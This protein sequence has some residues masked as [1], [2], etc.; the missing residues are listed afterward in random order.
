MDST[1]NVNPYRQHN[2]GDTLY[3]DRKTRDGRG[4]VRV[5]EWPKIPETR[6]RNQESFSKSL[7]ESVPTDNLDHELAASRKRGT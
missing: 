7:W 4:V 2:K 6:S 1:G 3:G 5:Q